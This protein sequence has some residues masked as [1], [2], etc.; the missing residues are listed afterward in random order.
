MKRIDV[1]QKNLLTGVSKFE[2]EYLYSICQVHTL[3]IS[4]TGLNFPNTFWILQQW[5][6]EIH[7]L[8]ESCSSSFNTTVSCLPLLLLFSPLW[9]FVFFKPSER[10]WC[11]LKLPHKPLGSKEHSSS[12]LKCHNNKLREQK[13]EFV[14]C[15]NNISTTKAIVPVDGRAHESRVHHHSSFPVYP[16]TILIGHQ[17]SWWWQINLPFILHVVHQRKIFFLF[18]W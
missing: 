4:Q 18:S 5:P 17:R 1:G 12:F 10:A 13:S 15:C 6:F 7:L 8:K 9:D 11:C 14:Q 2:A 16:G 3:C